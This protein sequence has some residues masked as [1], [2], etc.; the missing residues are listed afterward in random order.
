MLPSFLFFSAESRTLRYLGFRSGNTPYPADEIAGSGYA[1]TQRA[2]PQ[3]KPNELLFLPSS[4][5]FPPT[6]ENT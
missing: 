1:R 3:E 6:G 4:P 5:P 2:G